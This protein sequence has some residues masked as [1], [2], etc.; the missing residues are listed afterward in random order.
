MAANASVKSERDPTPRVGEAGLKRRIV[1]MVGL[2]ARSTTLVF[3]HRLSAPSGEAGGDA[4]EIMSFPELHQVDAVGA[5]GL[6]F[7][8]DGV[9]GGF[10]G[11]RVF[12]ALR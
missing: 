7:S 4:D 3:F 2:I 12:A 11:L 1:C 6:A 8:G 10:F 5:F 9:F